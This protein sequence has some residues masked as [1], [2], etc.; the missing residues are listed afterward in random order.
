MGPLD[1]GVGRV[2]L[3]ACLWLDSSRCGTPRW[4]QLGCVIFFFH[5]LFLSLSLGCVPCGPPFVKPWVRL[6]LGGFL[7]FI[8]L[9]SLLS[10]VP[11]CSVGVDLWVH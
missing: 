9:S 11:G 2:H 7:S 5:S 8:R 10:R 6:A 3:G 1:G 4:D